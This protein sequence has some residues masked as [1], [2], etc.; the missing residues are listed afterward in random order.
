MH[1]APSDRLETFDGWLN[2][3]QLQT[4]QPMTTGPE[5][6]RLYA[7]YLNDWSVD[8]VLEHDRARQEGG[9]QPIVP[10]VTLLAAKIA[11]AYRRQ[12]GAAQ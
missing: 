6:D 5:L 4:K 11:E 1:Q 2:R 12:R 7:F 3:Y 9:L 10:V 8:S